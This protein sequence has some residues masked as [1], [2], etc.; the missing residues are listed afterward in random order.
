[1]DLN[2]ETESVV[3]ASNPQPAML[4]PRVLRKETSITICTQD[5]AKSAVCALQTF[6]HGIPPNIREWIIP[7]LLDLLVRADFSPAMSQI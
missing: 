6:A 3:R 2:L 7:E 5:F 1:M 4:R